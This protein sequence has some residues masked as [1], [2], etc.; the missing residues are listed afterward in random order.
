MERKT[1]IIIGV[2]VL[3]IVIW[4]YYRSSESFTSI[5]DQIGGS[6]NCNYLIIP[7]SSSSTNEYSMDSTNARNLCK[8]CTGCGIC[9][10]QLGMKNISECVTGDKNGPVDS[11]IFCK[12][13]EYQNNQPIMNRS[14]TPKNN[15]FYGK[16]YCS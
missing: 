16:N 4:L 6:Q 5:S 15:F 13:Y 11:R 10:N 2:I 14:P 3:L 8:N 12:S 7:D 9:S 1:M